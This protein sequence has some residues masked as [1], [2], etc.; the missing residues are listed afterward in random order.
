[1]LAGFETKNQFNPNQHADRL[2]A[3]SVAITLLMVG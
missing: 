2:S 1:M 3:N